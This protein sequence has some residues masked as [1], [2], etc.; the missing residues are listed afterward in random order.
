VTEPAL[1]S[2]KRVLAAAGRT[3][4]PTTEPGMLIVD[5]CPACQQPDVW[6]YDDG[7]R[8]R[9]SCWR[10]GCSSTAILEALGRAVAERG[11]QD[12]A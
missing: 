5:E 12:A 9:G 11:R 6:L 8:L 10:S 4:R 2:A 1:D 7:Q 3:W